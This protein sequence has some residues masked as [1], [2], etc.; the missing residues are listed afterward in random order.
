MVKTISIALISL[1]I[2]LFSQSLFAQSEANYLYYYKVNVHNANEMLNGY[3]EPDHVTTQAATALTETQPEA[4]IDLRKLMLM[5]YRAENG[6]MMDGDFAILLNTKLTDAS[7]SA[8]TARICQVPVSTGTCSVRFYE[9][10]YQINELAIVSQPS[11]IDTN[12]FR[13]DASLFSLSSHHVLPK[14]SKACETGQYEDSFE[15]AASTLEARQL[16][17]NLGVNLNDKN[18]V[19]SLGK[20]DGTKIFDFGH[21]R[22]RR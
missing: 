20:P 6:V 21:P 2:S 3:I 1:M 7:K 18:S 12:R 17:T 11:W 15:Y 13:P 8:I 9:E 5:N 4:C 16:L 10:I 22:E 14:F 19:I